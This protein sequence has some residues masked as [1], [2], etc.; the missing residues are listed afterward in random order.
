M[1]DQLAIDLRGVWKRFD[2]Y[3]QWTLQEMANDFLHREKNTTP[4][5]FWAIKDLSL[6][7]KKG[8]VLGIIGTNGSGK[9]TLMKMLAKMMQPTQGV[10]NLQGQVTPLLSLSTGLVSHMTGR[11]NVFFSGLVMGMSPVQMEDKL[12][13]IL[14]FA[15]LG[16]A[17]DQP[18]RTYSTGMYV[19]L[20]FAITIYTQFDV[21]LMDELIAVGDISFQE[22]CA[23]QLRRFQKQ[24]KTIIMVSHESAEVSQLCDRVLYLDQGGVKACGNP[25]E[26]IRL[27]QQ[28]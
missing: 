23:Q 7:V 19:R 15:R 16:E 14:S 4:N 8:E 11:E 13:D 28:G 17:I 18:V 3:R 9:T 12:Y 22:S 10:I 6:Q 2:L 27:Y 5:S 21:L 25:Q 26:V 24:G 1:T 20:A